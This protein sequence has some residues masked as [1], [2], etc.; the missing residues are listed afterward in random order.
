METEP[1][2]FFIVYTFLLT[3]PPLLPSHNLF[4]LAHVYLDLTSL[5]ALLS[6]IPSK[7]PLSN[8]LKRLNTPLV[9]SIQ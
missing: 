4:I 2:T 3:P 6:F 5:Y 9:T 7:T 8:G 1:K